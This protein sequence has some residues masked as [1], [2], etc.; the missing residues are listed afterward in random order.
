MAAKLREKINDRLTAAIRKAFTPCPLIGANWLKEMPGRNPPDF[1]YYGIRRV[2]KAT[3]W[4]APRIAAAV[5][6]GLTWDDLGVSCDLRDD[7]LEFT[8]T[9]RPA[10]DN[11]KKQAGDKGRKPKAA[12]GTKAGKPKAGGAKKAPGKASRRKGPKAS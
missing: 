11:A 7:L 5:L 2:A 10:V 1:R 12:A 6:Q 9:D 4:S 3:G 8:R